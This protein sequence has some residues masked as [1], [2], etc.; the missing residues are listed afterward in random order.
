M[1]LPAARMQITSAA[2]VTLE[3]QNFEAGKKYRVNAHVDQ[4]NRRV[5]F[6]INEEQ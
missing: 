6:R 5:S 3:P 4:F 1:N 2:G